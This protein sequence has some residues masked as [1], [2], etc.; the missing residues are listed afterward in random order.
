MIG[1]S[2]PLAEMQ[3]LITLY[4]TVITPLHFACEVG[5]PDSYGVFPLVKWRAQILDV[6]WSQTLWPALEW[7]GATPAYLRSSS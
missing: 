1:R 7:P 3:K 4:L 2:S 6:A 5:Y